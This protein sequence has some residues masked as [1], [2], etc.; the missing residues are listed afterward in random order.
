[1]LH[2][3]ARHAGAEGIVTRDRRGFLK[4]RLR[5]YAPEELLRLVQ[6]AEES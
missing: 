1:M 6:A 4:A 5:V 2:E 3:A